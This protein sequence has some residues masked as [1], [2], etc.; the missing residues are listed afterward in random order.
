MAKLEKMIPFIIRWETG[1]VQKE[2]ETNEALWQRAKKSKNGFVFDPVDT[3]GATVVGVI[4]TTFVTYCKKKKIKE[5]SIED[6]KKMTYSMWFEILKGLYWNRWYA[7]Q[8]KSQSVAEMLV[9]W[10]WA[11]GVHGIKIPQRCLGVTDD[12]IV[13]AMTL[14]ALNKKEPKDFFETLIRER[15]AFVEGIVKRSPSQEKFIKG[16]KN[17]INDVKYND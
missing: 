6:L 5:D 12:G 13:G 11:S 14:D 9:D 3:G 1:T 17:R 7:D 10:V 8:I 4:Y 2:G 16:W 15:I